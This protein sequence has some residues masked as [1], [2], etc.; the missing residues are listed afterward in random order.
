MHRVI[1]GLLLGFG[2]GSMKVVDSSS[3]ALFF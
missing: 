3:A 2:F 1:L